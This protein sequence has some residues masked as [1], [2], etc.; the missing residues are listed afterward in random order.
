MFRV[1]HDPVQPAVGYRFDFQGRSVVV[2]GD[3]K[4]SENLVAH[5]RGADV[6]V[7]EALRSDLVKRA[8][9]V[10]GQTGRPRFAKLAGDIIGYHTDVLDVAGVARDAGVGQL[11]LTHLVPA[12]S[13][14]LTRRLFTR[15][16]GDVYSGPVTVGEDGTEITLAPR[17]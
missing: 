7:H 8:S 13:N 17:G 5:A 16:I 1:D 15:G 11:V 3:T 4:R 10:A 9:E 14:V 2:S 6:L 12:P